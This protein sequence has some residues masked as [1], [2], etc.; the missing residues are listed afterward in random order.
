[1]RDQL[2]AYGITPEEARA[3]VDALTDSEI[4]ALSGSLD[5]TPAGAGTE[6]SRSLADYVARTIA[7]VLFLPF[8]IILSVFGVP[9]QSPLDPEGA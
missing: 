8:E 3:R 6:A 7:A 2:A 5:D 1:M 9:H 4:A